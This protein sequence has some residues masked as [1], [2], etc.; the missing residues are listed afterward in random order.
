MNAA[1]RQLIYAALAVPLIGCAHSSPGAPGVPCEGCTTIYLEGGRQAVAQFGAA[2]PSAVQRVADSYCD[3]R[4]LGTPAIQPTPD[5]AT[6]PRWALYSFKCAEEAANVAA[7]QDSP[8]PPPPVQRPVPA[9]PM[10]AAAGDSDK[11]GA[12]C[13]SMAFQK[14]TPEYDGCVAKLQSMSA[15]AKQA[16]EQ[17]R[18]Q[19][20]RMIEQGLSALSPQGG[21][22]APTTIRLPS[23]E[24][25]TCTQT[26]GQV[27]CN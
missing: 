5:T 23:G 1:L 26:G 24:V 10:S 20:I 11:F 16:R 21:A 3:R 2:D 9:A 18:R 17:Q 14:G 19:A 7:A 12:M 25:L 15:E 8:V 13:T 27:T 6:Y 4:H 22:G